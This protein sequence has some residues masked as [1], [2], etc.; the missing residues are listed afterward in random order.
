M[1]PC[2]GGGGGGGVWAA[3]LKAYTCIMKC[4]V[5]CFLDFCTTQSYIMNKGIFN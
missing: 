5:S 4:P 3:G 1:C 2:W